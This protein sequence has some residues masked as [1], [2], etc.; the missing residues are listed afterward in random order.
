MTEQEVRQKATDLISSW[1]G[2]PKGSN[3]HHQI[4][5]IYNSHTPLPRGVRMSYSMDWCAATVSAVG[6]ALGLTDIMPVEC[7]CGELIKLYKALG[8]WVEDDAYIPKPGDLVLYAWKDDGVGDCK[9][10]PNH[11][12]MVTD[13][14]GSTITVVEG[15]AGSPSKVRSRQIQVDGRYIRGYCC[16]DYES[17][18]DK[19][20][21]STLDTKE[22][23][24]AEDQAWA[25][26]MGIAKG[27]DAGM[28]PEAPCTRAEV[29]AMLKRYHEAATAARGGD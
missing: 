9:K 5:D 18:A 24:Y 23:W 21:V 14:A 6:I 28:K 8:R 20:P 13:V 7:S 11:V 16:P 15:N 19:P 2:A 17:K 1:V 10:A 27:T 12:G 22:P 29:W 26:S 25:V 4:I 3:T